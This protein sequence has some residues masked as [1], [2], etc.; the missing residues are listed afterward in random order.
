VTFD[1]W[2]ADL[3][4]EARWRQVWSS[5][6]YADARYMLRLGKIGVAMNMQVVAC[7]DAKLARKA[8]FELLGADNEDV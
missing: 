5:T 3:L 4:K 1:E 7:L 2:R 8:L 6:S